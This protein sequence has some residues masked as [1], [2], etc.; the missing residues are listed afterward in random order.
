MKSIFKYDITNT[1]ITVITNYAITIIVKETRVI[2]G[3]GCTEMLMANAIDE[4]VPTVTG[5][6]IPT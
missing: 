2:C 4:K 1:V 5:R 3:G 6:Q